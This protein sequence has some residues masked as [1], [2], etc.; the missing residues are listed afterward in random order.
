MESS[1]RNRG[2]GATTAPVRAAHLSMRP[3]K[4]I[5]ESVDRRLA[6]ALSAYAILATIATIA[7]DGVLRMAMWAFFAILTYKTIRAP[8]MDD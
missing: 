4:Q 1:G 3:I 7:L 8:R 2:G 6:F 5:L